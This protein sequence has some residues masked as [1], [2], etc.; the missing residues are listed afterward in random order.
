MPTVATGEYAVI[1]YLKSVEI[2]VFTYLQ[3]V[4]GQKLTT[5]LRESSFAAM[6]RQEMTWF[7][8]SENSTGPVK[9]TITES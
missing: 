8:Q 2:F 1:I 4:A 5:R 3:P 7:D 9:L 6:L